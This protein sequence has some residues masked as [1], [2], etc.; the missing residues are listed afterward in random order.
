MPIRSCCRNAARSGLPAIALAVALLPGA[1]LADACTTPGFDSSAPLKPIP[2]V[3]GTPAALA[4]GS[5]Y[6]HD[7]EPGGCGCDLAVAVTDADPTK[8][9]LVI[10]R[11]ENNG[12]FVS[13]PEN[14]VFEIGDNPIALVSARFTQDRPGGH[15]DLALL[16]GKPGMA[17]SVA[18]FV[19][20]ETGSYRRSGSA[21]T[22]GKT[23]RGMV[24]GHFNQDSNLDIA[25]LS[26]D[27]AQQLTILF[28]DGAGGFTAE[29]P[30]IVTSVSNRRMWSLAAGK[31][32]G[33]SGPDDVAIANED[34][35]GNLR[36]SIARQSPTGGF[37]PQP[38]V[39]LGRGGDAYMAAGKFSDGAAAHHDLAVAFTDAAENG[40]ALVLVAGVQTTPAHAVA[41][42]PKSARAA[43]LDGDGRDDLIIATFTA[44]GTA[45]PDGKI[46][47]Y[48]AG[49]NGTVDF[50]QALWQTPPK[51]ILPRQ[52]MT[53]RFGRDPGSGVRHLGLAAAN[54]PDLN[55][56]SV[57]IGNGTGIFAAPAG[58]VTPIR[59]DAALFVTGDFHSE[60]GDDRLLDLAYVRPDETAGEHVI[61]VLLNNGERT[62]HEADIPAVRVG[63]APL[64]MAAGRFDGDPA[65]DLAVVDANPGDSQRR[66]R[67]RILRGEGAGKFSRIP[68][69]PDVLLES[70]ETPMAAAAGQ[71]KLVDESGPSDLAIVSETAAGGT[72]KLFLNDGTGR[73]AAG[74]V[75]RLSFKP[76]H[77]ASSNK[78]RKGG[79]YD[80]IVGDDRGFFLFLENSGDAQFLR[81]EGFNN[82][83]QDAQ[84]SG[85]LLVG[86][87]DKDDFD[88]VIIF[89]KDKSI[90]VFRNTGAGTFTFKNAEALIG[91]Q[92]SFDPA[93]GTFFVVD[94]GA[95]E[96]G[97]V[98]L[99]RPIG[100]RAAIV[101]A[102]GDGLGDF[103]DARMDLLE[104]KQPEGLDFKLWLPET[105]FILTTS[106]IAPSET[107][108][109][110][111]IFT[112]AVAGRFAN[113]ELGNEQPDFGFLS[114]VERTKIEPGIM[115]PTDPETN[116]GPDVVC[117]PA[118]DDCVNFIQCPSDRCIGG[119]LST[120]CPDP[121]CIPPLRHCR[122][123]CEPDCISTPQ[124]PFCETK[125][126]GYFLTV[127]RNT[128][129]G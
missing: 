78:F 121:P 107:A 63:R 38:P 113:A 80:V 129:D 68:G 15:D 115:C 106:N 112:S 44:T 1:A 86:G 57:Y 74:P 50:A 95:G 89:D 61:G 32:H 72:L 84:G 83:A 52:L 110:M 33:N 17:G 59:P 90:D 8:D 127:F 2:D 9:L 97:L 75:E 55:T 99:V 31:F 114:R 79:I 103:V 67:I 88:D 70:G 124:Q 104:L 66:A 54:A 39:L 25:V 109:V 35:A 19:P 123:E 71:F 92:P 6:Q 117:T 24:T 10:L 21:L 126:H 128:C 119:C 125:A 87:V 93:E 42:R 91:L 77:V 46:A 36:V 43:D 65:L 56:V 20:D 34:E 48:K 41:N 4:A 94:F 28:G 85:Q 23:A 101:A 40:K 82:P 69:V 102:K 5:Y 98:G 96:P 116:P 47:I 81:K 73:L 62:F 76:R 105:D 111:T 26:N 37:V 7:G 100:G 11:G 60:T 29:S 22:V 14:P 120:S 3:D 49:A 108:Q 45:T 53:G 13:R 118:P 30:A 18:L 12:G 64:L 122:A 27:P 16:T 51:P 58:F